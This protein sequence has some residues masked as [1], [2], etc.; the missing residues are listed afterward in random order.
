M[1]SAPVP[2]WLAATQRSPPHRPVLARLA[3]DQRLIPRRPV[4]VP[5]GC[6]R[7]PAA[8]PATLPQSD[9]L[10]RQQQRVERRAE[11]A[12]QQR[13]LVGDCRL[14]GAH[15]CP[16]RASQQ[17]QPPVHRQAL[18]HHDEIVRRPRCIFARKRR[19]RI[20]R[21]APGRR[22][23]SRDRHVPFERLQLRTFPLEPLQRLLLS[24]LLRGHIPAAAQNGRH[25]Q[26]QIHPRKLGHS[27]PRRVRNGHTHARSRASGVT[28]QEG[29]WDRSS[30]EWGDRA[31]AAYA[32]R[33]SA[34]EDGQPAAAAAHGPP[35]ETAALKTENADEQEQKNRAASRPRPEP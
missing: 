28:M 5:A 24:H 3:C 14:G 20:G 25:A 2:G 7:C 13:S 11:L 31:L 10:L 29:L 4:A 30:G 17:A 16:S 19:R 35:P 12:A 18:L 1:T 26:N 27:T 9:A 15:L 21:E 23:P 34:R 32:S 6:A 22:L 33:L 8:G